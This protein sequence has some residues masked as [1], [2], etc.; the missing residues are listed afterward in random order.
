[1]SDP[2]GILARPAGG[3]VA[4]NVATLGAG[5]LVSRLIGFTA[6]VYIARTLGA[7]AYGVIGFGLAVLLYATTLVD[8]GLEHTGPREVAEAGEDLTDLASSLTIARLLWAA[9]VAL[10]VMAAAVLF[11]SGA[12]RTVLALYGVALLP[13]GAYTRWLHLGLQRTGIVSA[14][15]VTSDVLR[16]LAIFALVRGPD[17]LI[18]VPLAEIG[19]SVIAAAMLL[20]GMRATGVRLRPRFDAALTRRVLYRAAPMAVSALLAVMIYNADLIFLRVF[21]TPAEVGLYLAGYTLLNFLG[22]LGHVLALTLVPAFTRLRR[23]PAELTGLYGDAVAR[24]FAAGLPVAVGGSLIAPLL[25]LL[26]FGNEYASSAAVLA[27][28]VWSLPVLLL[29]SV[30]QAGLIASGRQ[31]LVLRTTLA[32]AGANVGLNFVA[33][34]LLGMYGAALTT[35]IAETLRMATAWTYLRRQDYPATSPARFVRSA[36]AAAA[37]GGVLFLL[38]PATVWAALALGVAAYATGLLITGGLRVR[39]YSFEVT[40]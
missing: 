33:V 16:V 12:E 35:L 7:E 5:E 22:I 19:G 1:M 9:V 13:V 36:A 39:R 34:P 10:L 21:R 32:A 3:L 2:V 6:T 37:M 18:I 17:D 24:A 30:F 40:V 25:I 8:A 29:R 11:F 28:L 38:Q 4:R 14:A 26:V 23:S 31:D 15:R 20:G 27:I